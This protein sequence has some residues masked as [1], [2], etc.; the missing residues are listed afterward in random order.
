M[1]QRFIELGQG[2]SDLYELLEVGRNNQHRVL[3]LLAMHS[4]F[5]DKPVTSLAIV[6]TPTN[7][8]DF[9]PIYMCREGIPNP[10]I[11]PN[12][13]YDL[14]NE[15]SSGLEVPIIQLEVKSSHY[16]VDKELYH[17]YL[18]GILRLNHLIAPMK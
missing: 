15:L 13:R 3:R 7:P 16:F 17:Q 9:Q 1:I 5:E 10:T 12:K 6:L 2:Y 11:T 14:F 18:I 4:T 8:G